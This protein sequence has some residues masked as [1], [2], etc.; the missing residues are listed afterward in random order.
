[1]MRRYENVIR[2]EIKRT[3][4]SVGSVPLEAFGLELHLSGPRRTQSMETF[5]VEVNLT[6]D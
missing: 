2:R 6:A 5:I 3:K 1:M 4:W